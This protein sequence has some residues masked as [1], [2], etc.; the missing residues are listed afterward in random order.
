MDLAELDFVD[1]VLVRVPLFFACGVLGH[2]LNLDF[3]VLS[4]NFLH[5]EFQKAIEASYLLRDQSMLLKVCLNH[6]PGVV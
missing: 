2:L 4:H 1:H 5:V 3:S 6:C